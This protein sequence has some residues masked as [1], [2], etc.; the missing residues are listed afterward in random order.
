MLFPASQMQLQGLTFL[1]KA[2]C[3]QCAGRYHRGKTSDIVRKPIWQSS[4]HGWLLSLLESRC[5]A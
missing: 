5:D 1:K 2:L 3:D 4:A